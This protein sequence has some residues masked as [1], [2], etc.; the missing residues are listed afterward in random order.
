MKKNKGYTLVE[1]IIVIAIMAIMTGVAFV[2]LNVIHQAKYTTAITTLENEISTLWIKTKAISQ[3]SVQTTPSSA[4]AKSIYPLGMLISENKDSSDDVRDGSYEV[5]L[6]YYDGTSFIPKEVTAVLTDIIDIKYTAPSSDTGQKHTVL[7][8]ENTNNYNETVFIQFNKSDG[9]V[10][11]GAGTYEIYY[12][13][14]SVGAVYLDPV[15]GNH[16]VK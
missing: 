8:K 1:L 3:G 11:Y 6:G 14:D 2:T 10:R 9:S 4:D 5:I 13:D 15:T 7:T 12:N 16:Y